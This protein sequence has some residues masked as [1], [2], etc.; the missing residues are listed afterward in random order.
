MVREKANATLDGSARYETLPEQRQAALAA[1]HCDNRLAIFLREQYRLC[2]Y[3]YD[4]RDELGH[5][6]TI[7]YRSIFFQTSEYVNVRAG[8]LKETLNITR[9]I[10]EVGLAVWDFNHFVLVGTTTQVLRLR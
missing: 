6:A 8:Q 1:T 9:A 3:R 2:S 4:L 10:Q 7:V 5:A